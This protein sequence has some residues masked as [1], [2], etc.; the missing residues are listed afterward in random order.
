MHD[1]VL[2]LGLRHLLRRT[3]H[4]LSHEGGIGACLPEETI[5]ES[6]QAR[7]LAHEEVCE[8]RH[9]RQQR[10]S[11]EGHADSDAITSTGAR[12]E[13]ANPDVLNVLSG[14]CLLH[15]AELLDLRR[16]Q[17]K[18]PQEALEFVH[19]QLPLEREADD[20]PRRDLG[21]EVLDVDVVPVLSRLV[22]VDYGVGDLDVDDI[23]LFE[24]LLQVPEG[25]VDRLVTR[26]V[27]DGVEA[28]SPDR[29]LQTSKSLGDARLAGLFHW[30][31]AYPRHPRSRSGPLR[32]RHRSIR[33]GG[34]RED[35]LC[36][37]LG[38]PGSTVQGPR[39]GRH[40]GS[41]PLPR[42]RF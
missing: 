39:W 12:R 2:A 10:H 28:G 24:E 37:T 25:G 32:A 42:R 31:E 35:R 3:R 1:P 7:F 26:R 40:R 13:H 17:A 19:R 20:T 36:I 11:T 14:Q 30:H 29:H 8:S 16:L 18:D 22:P 4:E 21:H 34:R 9:L 33:R 15:A 5:L 38:Q 27:V 23:L 6:G 41:L